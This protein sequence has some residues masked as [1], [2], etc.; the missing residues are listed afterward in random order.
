MNHAKTATVSR[1]AAEILLISVLANILNTE[2]QGVEVFPAMGVLR[3]LPP[4]PLI[5]ERFSLATMQK[6][7][8][9]IYCFVCNAHLYVTV[10]HLCSPFF[11]NTVGVCR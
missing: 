8:T 1:G 6:P 7:A 10:T 5:S 2:H 4:A 9:L 3:T 11:Q